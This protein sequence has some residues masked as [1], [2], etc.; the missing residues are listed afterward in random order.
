MNG[1]QDVDGPQGSL[2]IR[3]RVLA[4]PSLDL[5]ACALEVEIAGR[6]YL[7]GRVGEGF[8]RLCCEY[9]FRTSRFQDIFL[10]GSAD[11]TSQMGGL[12]GLILTLDELAVENIQ[13]FGDANVPW[14]LASLR[15]FF[16]REACDISAKRADSDFHDKDLVVV[17]VELFGA[18]DAAEAHVS[19][20]EDEAARQAIVD[21]GLKRMFPHKDRI[22]RDGKK[23]LSGQT[24][25]REQYDTTEILQVVRPPSPSR[26]SLSYIIQPRPPRGKFDENL[27]AFYRLPFGPE[28]AE[29][30]NGKTWTRDDGLDVTTEMVTA[31]PQSVRRM[32]FIDIPTLQHLQDAKTKNW[33]A[34][35][36]KPSEYLAGAQTVVDR[37]PS[38]QEIEEE[39]QKAESEPFAQR[40]Y[41]E[42]PVYG[43]VVHDLGREVEPFS[44]EFISF[45]KSF[46]PECDH[47]INHPDYTPNTLTYNRAAQFAIALGMISPTHFR[48]PIITPASKLVDEK[49][50]PVEAEEIPVKGGGKKLTRHQ[51]KR[52]AIQEKKEREVHG[53]AIEP[54][55]SPILQPVDDTPTDSPNPRPELSVM[56]IIQGTTYVLKGKLITS[57]A[58]K[59]ATGDWRDS[60]KLAN[61]TVEMYNEILE[62]FPNGPR[63]IVTTEAGHEGAMNYSALEKKNLIENPTDD[64]ASSS[65]NKRG[66]SASPPSQKKKQRVEIANQVTVITCGTGSATPAV[67]RNVIGT[68]VKLP[69]YPAPDDS[70]SPLRTKS[71]LLDC[72]ESTV[73]NLRRLYGL[74]GTDEILREIKVVFISHL[75]ADHFFGVLTFLRARNDAFNGHTLEEGDSRT[76]YIVG[77]RRMILWLQE[78]QQ[79]HPNLTADVRF[80]ENRYLA[81]RE[82]Y[83]QTSE[84]PT[85]SVEGGAEEY[86][87][88]YED[89]LSAMS[90]RKV[91]T[92]RAVHAQLA[93]SVAFTFKNGFKLAYSGDTRP[94]YAFTQIGRDAD[95]LVHE[96]TMEDDL[97]ASAISKRHS[98]LSEALAVGYV[99]NAKNILLTHFSQRYPVSISLFGGSSFL[100]SES[101]H[102]LSGVSRL[103]NEDRDGRFI[104]ENVET[105]PSDRLSEKGKRA[106]ERQIKWSANVKLSFAY[107][108]MQMQLA[109][110]DCQGAWTKPMRVMFCDL[111][112]DLIEQDLEAKESLNGKLL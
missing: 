45:M 85:T 72:G 30:I 12:P 95:L 62:R 18:S 7:F 21:T 80:V 16:Q 64:N 47:I 29:V 60:D 99:M 15:R 63:R 22:I 34:R 56:P 84:H 112:R 20:S 24:E 53:N 55:P 101:D 8:Q 9:G 33:F 27:A 88:S 102:L 109:D 42:Q 25:M 2:I 103:Q 69:F 11:W 59:I 1:T 28:R 36:P 52:K 79:L 87:A 97:L 35:V 3:A 14:A 94:N 13:V 57:N 44:E 19:S 108:G 90:L 40:V 106:V 74:S 10:S 81:E 67:F 91:A 61:T 83:R 51:K 43:F 46:G 38:Q 17:P 4:Q 48:E 54:P 31:P 110:F 23:Q 50:T 104:R 89:L 37:F 78:W 76:L 100:S 98:T 70:G 77:S 92:C 71:V 86:K 26:P 39:K 32:A 65:E 93:H 82:T 75:H 58:H 73:Q 6:S 66:R 96:A 5:T 41:F 111:N 68:I 105:R 49:Y 107:D